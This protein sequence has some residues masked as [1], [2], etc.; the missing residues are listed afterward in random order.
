MF[1]PQLNQMSN[2]LGR[3]PTQAGYMWSV[4]MV[5]LATTLS[6]CF[7]AKTPVLDTQTPVTDTEFP[8]LPTQVVH[9][10]D[11]DIEVRALAP[12]QLRWSD[13]ATWGGTLPKAGQVVTI[14]AGK[15]ILLDT[16]P[17][18][19]GGLYI[20]GAL[21]FDSDRDVE[22][23]SEWL[24]IHGRL[25][26]GSST[27]PFPK[28]ATITL[29]D[30]VPNQNVMGMGDK[31]IAVMGGAIEAIG[32]GRTSWSR[33]AAP[34]KAGDSSITL[35]DTPVGWQ[36][37]DEIVIASTDYAPSQTEKMQ[38]ISITDKTIGL[39]AQLKYSHW[40]SAS[41]HGPTNMMLS[42]RAEVGMLNRNVVIQG[43][44]NSVTAGF[45]G[46]LMIMGTGQARINNV[47]FFN[48]GQKGLLKRYP[49]H[50][51][52]VQDASASYITNSAIAQSYN[53]CLVIHGTH[54]LRVL[55]NVAFDTIGHCFF[56]EDGI[57]T[58]NTLDKNLALLIKK[59][60]S[61]QEVLASDKTPSAFWITNPD[62]TVTN[63]VAAAAAGHGFW[64]ALPLHPLNLSQSP[65]S[66]ATIWPRRT[67]LL[68]FNSNVAHSNE[69]NGLHVDSGPKAD[70]TTEGAFYDPHSSP[71]PAVDGYAD[72]P[73]VAARFENLTSYKNR[74]QGAW[75]RGYGLYV[76]GGRFADNPIGVTMASNESGVEDSLFLGETS[77][78]GTPNSWDPKGLD[79][80]SLGRPWDASFPIRGFEFYD[81]RVWVKN[82][83]FGRYTS[84]SL[85]KASGLSYLRQN[86]FTIDQGNFADN[87]TWLDTSN[88]VYFEEP[89]ADRD[90]DKSSVFLDRTG[91]V[92]GTASR[93]IVNNNPFLR[94]A[95]GCT[96]R[97]EWNGYVCNLSYGGFRIY[98][99]SKATPVGPITVSRW[100][101]VSTQLTGR[102]DDRYYFSG[103]ILS[104]TAN[105][106]A[107]A[108]T[109]TAPDKMRVY[110]DNRNPTNFIQVTIPYTG[111]VPYI[112]KDW[113]VN[114]SNLA[115]RVTAI[116]DLGT[117]T[118]TSYYYDGKNLTLRLIVG[119]NR[120]SALVDICRTDLCN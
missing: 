12:G 40:S 31:V 73:R 42:T 84:N 9:Y 59:P 30:N 57:E 48:M 45:G 38:I 88:R 103:S 25:Q 58:K 115:T 8:P 107:F 6:G 86:A 74:G 46:Q 49:I 39:S 113:W 7:N 85:R 68:S 63:N 33:L 54:N 13:P 89:Q 17:P 108:G 101:G 116:A 69:G 90:G 19:L 21:Q 102:E 97:P 32:Q 15:N 18:A 23:Q 82:S 92:S 2:F 75:L 1:N 55:N 72:S 100:D 79:G 29:V 114:N 26:I 37:G 110:L 35:L 62:N 76:V 120:T 81:G 71:I 50:F 43:D 106:I 28:K 67:A 60:A 64:Y 34:V 99:L 44:A 52:L 98:D 83:V 3:K 27:V 11:S 78:V 51:H 16:N 117:A 77:N 70:G 47:R 10:P 24:M 93:M 4:L 80:R 61:G 111:T 105:K 119:T 91:S 41:F 87:L 20:D 65:G 95:T 109:A 5:V 53:R 66:D 14:P 112:Y 118:A 56:L 96:S 94:T 104:N 22:L 36:V